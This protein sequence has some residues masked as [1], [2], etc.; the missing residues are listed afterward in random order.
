M[1]VT[2]DVQ[3]PSQYPADKVFKVISDFDNLAP[4]VNPQFIKSIETVQGNGDVGTIK[5]LTFGDA[6]PYKS[7]KY[8]V[9]AVDPSNYSYDYSVIEGD[10]LIGILDSIN[11]HVKIV[12]SSNG[13]SVYTQTV[14]YNCKGAEKPSEEFLKK[15]KEVY[16][17][18]YKAI[19]A[20]AAAHPEVY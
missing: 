12:P 2:L 4:K 7:A 6:V 9:D 8:K 19:E 1:S 10:S 17:N 18:S 5:N 15:E 11:H 13:G 3:V 14:I 16:E 20:Y